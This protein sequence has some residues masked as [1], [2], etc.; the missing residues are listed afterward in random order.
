LQSPA[1]AVV[2]NKNE[3]K[4]A[5]EINFLKNLLNYLLKVKFYLEDLI[6]N[7]DKKQALNLKYN[8]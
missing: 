2:A 8:H 3:P 1:L 7:K 4:K 6:M 5:A